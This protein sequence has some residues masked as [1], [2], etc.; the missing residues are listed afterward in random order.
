MNT[1]A[2][3]FTTFYYTYS[4]IAQTLASAFAFLTALFILRWPEILTRLEKTASGNGTAAKDQPKDQDAMSVGEETVDAAHGAHI[5]MGGM[6]LALTMTAG[7]IAVC[8]VL[9]PSTSL[10][11][12]YFGLIVAR[13]CLV[14]TI[15]SALLCLL[16]Y[17]NMLLGMMRL[18]GYTFS[19]LQEIMAREKMLE[20]RQ[21]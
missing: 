15:A 16:L 20:E 10:V 3:D 19:R 12:E 2:P 6:R 13:A 21:P 17:S 11:A 5:V 14:L 18:R 9:M 1:V 8:F 4:T 7:T